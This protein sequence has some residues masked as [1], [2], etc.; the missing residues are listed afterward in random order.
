[1]GA[2]GVGKSTVTREVAHRLT[3][4]GF[5]VR[6]VDRW[7]IVASPDYPTAA[8]LRDDVLSV[9]S[10]T[11]RMSRLPRLLFLLWATVL[12]LTDC[13]RPQ[14]PGEVL[15]LDGHWM[16]HAASEIAYGLDRNWV[17]ALV[18]GLPQASATVYLRSDPETAWERKNGRPV[19]YECAM[20]LAC[21]RE[22]FL[23]HQRTIHDLLDQW[24]RRL[25]W[26]EVDARRPLNDVVAQA[27]RHARDA[28]AA[29]AHGEPW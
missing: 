29:A 28:A 1:M 9:R 10:C 2:D 26:I 16:K 27:T 15:V 23:A 4:D 6:P 25:G 24:A 22:S 3:A 21:S 8:F 20:D 14:S 19:P 12:P 11:A 7:E 5:P 13:R 18:A 17:E